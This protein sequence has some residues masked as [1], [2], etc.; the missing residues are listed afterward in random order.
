MNILGKMSRAIYPY[1]SRQNSGKESD[2]DV[3]VL[4]Q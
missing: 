3:H 2:S 4:W 1:I